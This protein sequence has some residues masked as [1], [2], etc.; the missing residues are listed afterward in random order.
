M[1]ALYYIPG[2]IESSY[3]R[4]KDHQKDYRYYCTNSSSNRDR[5]GGSFYSTDNTKA[6]IEGDYDYGLHS[7]F[8]RSHS[9]YN[10]KVRG[11][12]SRPKYPNTDTGWIIG[13]AVD[14][15]WSQYAKNNSK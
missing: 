4:R 12:K 9:R 8:G 15:Y 3:R 14:A 1:R 6:I 13:P 11:L 2:D 10:P 5:V 7:F